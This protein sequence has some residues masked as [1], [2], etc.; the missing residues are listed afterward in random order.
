MGPIGVAHTHSTLP[1][2]RCVNIWG[3]SCPRVFTISP[4][5]FSI[6]NLKCVYVGMWVCSVCASVRALACRGLLVSAPEYIIPW[7]FSRR[8]CPRAHTEQIAQTYIIYKASRSVRG[9]LISL[10]ARNLELRP[11]GMG[12][13]EKS[14]QVGPGTIPLDRICGCQETSYGRE[15]E[16]KSWIWVP[17][18]VLS[19]VFGEAVSSSPQEQNSPFKA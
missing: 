11:E 7:A 8:A 1:K 13:P 18:A 10:R 2:D 5:L 9:N 6:G 17:K 3:R 4:A 15:G 16:A 12:G 19:L 14:P